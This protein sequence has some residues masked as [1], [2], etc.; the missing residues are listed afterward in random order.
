MNF[1][2]RELRDAL[3]CFATGVCVVTGAPEG[4][5]PFGITVNSFASVSLDPPLIL[6]SL[7]NQSDM[8]STFDHCTRWA[9][10]VLAG[11]QEQLSNTYAARGEHILD[12]DHYCAGATGVPVMPDSLASFECELESRFPGGDHVILLARVVALTQRDKG[13][14][15]IFC[16]GRYNRLA[17]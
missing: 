9:V 16:S 5:A 14:P 8:F 10:N 15:L 1:D 12:P 6:W 11:D 2:S 4:G 3:G 17:S 13:A 7:Q